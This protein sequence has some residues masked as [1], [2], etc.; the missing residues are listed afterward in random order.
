MWYC[1]GCKSSCWWKHLWTP[2]CETPQ[3]PLK[4]TDTATHVYAF[5]H[6]SLK[7]KVSLCPSGTCHFKRVLWYS[8]FIKHF[9]KAEVSHFRATGAHRTEWSLS[10]RFSEHYT[11]VHISL[12]LDYIKKC[13]LNM[14]EKT[15]C[16]FDI[17]IWNWYIIQIYGRTIQ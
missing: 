4:I 16:S 7:W 10:N 8:L 6:I 14:F 1:W 17:F 3:V 13:H 12:F 5:L 11:L 15:L 9:I 2:S